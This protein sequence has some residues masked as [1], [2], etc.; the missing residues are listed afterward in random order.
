MLTYQDIDKRKRAFIF[1]LDDVLYPQKDYLL[2]VYYLFANLLEYTET[3]PPANDLIVFFKKTYEH[4]GPNNIFQRAAAVFGINEKYRENFNRLHVHAK[5][6]L[7]LLLF[8]SMKKM[9]HE[10]ISDG[11][12]VYVLTRGNPLM[13]LNKLKQMEW[14]GIDQQLKAYFFDDMVLQGYS[15]PINQ[16]LE[17]H[18]LQLKEVLLIGAEKSYNV[19]D[20]FGEKLDYM[21]VSLLL[22][23]RIP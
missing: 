12:N 19:G 5:L 10:M 17:D 14:E 16:L 22:D 8:P 9:L 2:Q 1:E 20:K 21:P 11:K 13:Q 4:H 15:N 18:K 23:E 3:V 7:K 6:P